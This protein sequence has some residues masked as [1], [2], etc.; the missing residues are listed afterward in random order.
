VVSTV[1]ASFEGLCIPPAM[2]LS[3]RQESDIQKKVY[4]SSFREK[5]MTCSP[6][7]FILF[8]DFDY[9][10]TLK[11]FFE[12]KKQRTKIVCHFHN[13]IIITIS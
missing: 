10:T 8:H 11:I 13:N 4:H 6:K 7:P 12:S 3:K 1:K 9:G 5:L 2:T